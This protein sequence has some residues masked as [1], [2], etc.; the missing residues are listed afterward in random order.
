MRRFPS[1]LILRAALAT[2]MLTML[3]EA[4][5]AH[6]LARPQGVCDLYAAG[7]T[8]C[9][10]AHSS[11]RALFAAYTGPLYQVLRQ[12]DGKTLDIGVVPAS[13]TD[14]GGYADAAAQDAFCANTVC[15]ISVLYDQSG[16]RND[17]IQPPRGAF[18]GPAMGGFDNLPIA[19]MAPVTVMG[20]KVYGVLVAPGMGLRLNNAH[21][22]AVD[23]QAE[24]I[25]WVIDGHHFNGGCCFDYGNA[26]TDSRDDGNGTMET[27]FFG[28]TPW[29]Y[30]GNP[31]GPWIMTDQENNLVGCV[32]ADESKLCAQ[33]PDI[34]WRF[35]TAMAKG[36]AHHWTTLGGDAQ[37]GALSV[38][39]DGPRIDSTYDP[40]RKQGAIVLGN[41]GDNSNGSQ[42]T[43]YEGA[44]TAA[45]TFPSDAVDQKVQANVVAAQYGLPLVTL[46]PAAQTATPPGLQTFSPGA[47]Q[48]VAVTFT[49]STGAPVSHVTLSV[50]TPQG[51]SVRLAGAGKTAKTVPGPILPGASVQATFRVTSSRHPSNGELVGKVVWSDVART[52]RTETAAEK[53]RTIAPIKINEFRVGDG[54]ADTTN[55]FIELYNPQARPIDLSHWSLTLRPAGEPAFSSIV[56]PS[57]TVLASHGFYVLG[58]S[59]SGMA[60]PASAGADT[61]Y[62]RNTDGL[63]VGDSVEIGSGPDRESRKIVR[64]GTAAAPATTLWQPTPDGPVIAIPAGST[65][66]PVTR[67][68]GF[69]V[70]EKIALGYGAS[71]PV[72][73]LGKEH[74][75]LA[76]VTAVG[77]PGTQAYL[78][79]DAVAGATRLAVRDGAPVGWPGKDMSRIDAIS[80]G[81]TIVL[82]IDSVGHG[83]ETVTVK[84]VG[85]ATVA[86]GVG[87]AAHAGDTVIKV[88]SAFGWP[89]PTKI[90]FKPGDNIVVGT[91]AN[92][93]VLTVVGVKAVDAKIMALTVDKPLA[94]THLVGE[95]AVLLGS[96]LELTA[97][98]KF[99]HA[100]NTPFSVR[101]T[102]IA[103]TPAS[104]QLHASNEPVQALGTGL[105]LDAPL[106]KSHDVNAV[107][108]VH[109][110][111]NA[112]FQGTPHQWF[113]GPVLSATAGS[114]VLRDA[115]GLTVDSLNYGT[116]VD[117]WVAEGSQA[118]SGFEKFGCFVPV[119]GVSNSWDA[120]NPIADAS[121]GRYPDG[122]DRDS[123]CSDFRVPVVSTLVRGTAAGGASLNVASVKNFVA[124]E[125]VTID[126]DGTRETATIVAVGT[127][128]GTQANLA[129]QAGDK[130]IVVADREGFVNGQAIAIDEN[131]NGETAVIAG[132]RRQGEGDQILLAEPL[133]RAH[134]A[135]VSV[136]GT[137]LT[138][139]TAL[140]YAHPRGAPIT[141]DLPTPG[142]PNQY[143]QA[144]R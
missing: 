140:K 107:V 32:N 136:A 141:T 47:T 68:T 60:A 74:M 81:D 11:T 73:G 38:M 1:K 88:H 7:G 18:S 101:G 51:W 6:G 82:D 59:N 111:G 105:T 49:N 15:W 85:T 109:A 131:A 67:T 78:G 121:A 31:P 29:W 36:K 126:R 120:G 16:H 53:V 106:G 138:L 98:L 27:T 84:S 48:D 52:T 19:T 12:S 25:Y 9:V 46:A 75:E 97:P 115:A 56:L 112:G 93:E 65:T 66:V 55:S 102:G 37:K 10:A 5:F 64:V 43:F 104:T 116:V 23:D 108:R 33:L 57:K 50:A 143:G 103:F 79:A 45:G 122:A 91:P 139:R 14:A 80:P 137:G 24:G 100:A 39:F 94:Q 30:H 2:T 28:N 134:A 123:N 26:E 113:G 135:G 17:L 110:V 69:A 3:G 95:D 144:S 42:G 35:V 92:A 124:G 76:T 70:G 96:G 127:A 129:I 77:K 22:V 41:G 13:A 125:T 44:M 83:S 133:K 8:P 20:H 99:A 117:P 132:F 62:V 130:A 63:K 61:I 119:P 90:D 114:M 54:S 128:G 4:G 142:K 58:L 72:V 86:S 34:S 71:Y 21:G 40:M 87:S 118:I 89:T